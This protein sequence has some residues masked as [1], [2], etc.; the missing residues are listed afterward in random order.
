MACEGSDRICIIVEKKKIQRGKVG[1]FGIKILNILDSEEFQ[2]T[3]NTPNPNP[4]GYK[5]DNSE[6]T[7]PALIIN[8]QSRPISIKKNEERTI[9]IGIQVPKDAPV[10]GVYILNVEIRNNGNL[11]A[12][13]SG[14]DALQ[15]M[16]VEVV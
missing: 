12:P 6:I 1:I 15:K 4:L 7:G 16:Y 14:R 11:Y 3:V 10:G 5:K 8:P 2:I 9:G 13:T